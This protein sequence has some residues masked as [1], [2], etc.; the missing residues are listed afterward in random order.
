MMIIKKEYK[1]TKTAKT[2]P[3]VIIAATS[4]VG[5]DGV[6][7]YAGEKLEITKE[8]LDKH[9]EL[10]EKFDLPKHTVVP[11]TKESEVVEQSEDKKTKTQAKSTTIDADL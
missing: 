1:M 7:H 3:I 5:D 11:S 2:N 4:F 6:L 10:S 8:L 9:N